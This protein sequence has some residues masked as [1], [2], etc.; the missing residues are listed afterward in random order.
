MENLIG[1]IAAKLTIFLKI[2]SKNTTFGDIFKFI[3]FKKKIKI[4]IMRICYLSNNDMP[5]KMANSIQ[6][7]KMCEAF[8]QN[9][10]DVLLI[11]PNSEKLKIQFTITMM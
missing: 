9:G 10:N 4:K 3:L 1:K 5:S 11:C 2:F 6:T 8:A 7:I